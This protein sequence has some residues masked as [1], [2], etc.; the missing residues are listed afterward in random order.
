MLLRPLSLLVF[1]AVHGTNVVTYSVTNMAESTTGGQKFTNEIR[2][3]YSRQ[4]MLLNTETDRKNIE[5]VTL[6]IDDMDGVAYTS[7]DEIHEGDFT[8]VLYHEMTHVWQLSNG[9]PWGLIERILDYVRLKV[10]YAPSHWVHPGEG[11]KW[12]KGYDVT[13]H[14]LDYCNSLCNGFVAELN[15]KMKDGY[16]A[17]FFVQLIGKTV[18]HLWSEYKAKYQ[19]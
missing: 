5:Q 19:P 18:D 1:V 13:A 6:F 9:A 16:N 7:N 4:T 3:D 8:R 14:F 17:E 15:E 2:S 10:G 11:D 12:D